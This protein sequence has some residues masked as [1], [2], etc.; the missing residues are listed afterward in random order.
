MSIRGDEATVAANAR[1]TALWTSLIVLAL[2]L[3]L[4][5]RFDQAD[6]GFQFV[7]SAAWL[8]DWGIT[9]H[10]GVDGISVLFVLLSTAA[11]ADLHPGELGVDH[12]PGARVHARVPDPRDDDGGHVLRPRLRRLLHVLRGRADPDVPHHRGLG[13]PAAGLRGDEVLSVH[14]D[15]LGADA[16]GAAGHVVS[17]RHDR[18]HGPAAHHLP[19][20][21]CRSGC[22][23]PSLPRSR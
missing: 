18:H 4:W 23:S 15:R 21:R 16:A 5:A 14:A 19:A 11:H 7:E 9:Y 20:M 12:R 1:W 6:P 13:R 3:V 22:S 2:S 8:P 10:M 17:G